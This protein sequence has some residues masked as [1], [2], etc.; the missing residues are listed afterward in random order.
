MPLIEQN[1][2]HSNYKKPSLLI[3]LGLTGWGL[4]IFFLN[5]SVNSLKRDLSIDVTFYSPFF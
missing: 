1:I 3:F 2:L 4:Q 5:L